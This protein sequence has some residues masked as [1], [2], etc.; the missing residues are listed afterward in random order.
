MGAHVLNLTDGS[1]TVQLATDPIHLIEYVPRS[2]DLTTVDF[3]PATLRDGGERPVTRRRN[4]TETARV[5]FTATGAG[6]AQFTAANS[7]YLS[8]A[9][10]SGLQTGDVDFWIAAWVRFD[11]LATTQAFV[12][13]YGGG[14]TGEYHLRFNSSRLRFAV[15]DG[16]SSAEVAADNLGLPVANTWY[17]VLVWHD[18]VNSRIRIRVNHGTLDSANLAITV[19][20]QS[21]AFRISSRDNDAD[22]LGG[23]VAAVAFGKSPGA[24]INSLADTISSRLYN[25]G[26]G[27]TYDDLT[28]AEKSAWGLVSWWQLDEE[29]GTRRDS[30]ATPGNHLTDNNTVTAAEWVRTLPNV[31]RARIRSVETLLRQAEQYQEYRFGGPVYVQFQPGASGDT[32]RSEILSGRL[33]LSD[34]ALEAK[35]WAAKQVEA[36]AMWTRRYYWEDNTERQVPLSNGNGTN[37]TSGLTVYNHEDAH[38]GHDNFLII[39]AA[40][41]RGAIPAACR[42]EITNTYSDVSRPKTIYL[43]QKVWGNPALFA[44]YVDGEEGSAGSGGSFASQAS[45]GVSSNDAYGRYTWT[46]DSEIQLAIWTLDSARLTYAAGTWHQL[47]MRLV[48]TVSGVRIRWKLIFGTVTVWSGAQVTLDSNQ[49][50]QETG[51]VQLPPNLAGWTDYQAMTLALYAQKT[52]GGTLDIDYVQF[53]PLDS[54]RRFTADAYHLPLNDRLVDDGIADRLYYE[55]SADNS[56]AQFHSARGK[57]LMLWPGRTQRLYLLATSS[58]NTA[59]ILLTMTV[60]LYYRPRRLTL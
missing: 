26:S 59:P 27:L 57:R 35:E 13:K 2:P 60:K 30:H 17:F 24:G 33:E 42:L 32:Y 43:G 46:G 52:G 37:N 3:D 50:L 44:H 58:T 54:W 31:L 40:D 39:N 38:A 7:E 56:H 11:S 41:V 8:A 4:V 1:T 36:A 25:S 9:S 47:L 10:N 19:A 23:R 21:S 28:A 51:T 5:L 22:F 14:S 55:D 48:N 20:A 16:S 49:I 29:S 45:V 53:F 12:S 18:A 34:T 15:A 6:A